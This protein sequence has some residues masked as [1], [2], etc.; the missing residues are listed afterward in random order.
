[1]VAPWPTKPCQHFGHRASPGVRDEEGFLEGGETR[2]FF[3]YESIHKSF[4]A[5]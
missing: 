2:S 1:M 4:L 5:T 3:F